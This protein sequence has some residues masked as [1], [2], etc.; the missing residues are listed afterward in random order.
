ML[1]VVVVSRLPKLA[2]PAVDPGRPLVDVDTLVAQVLTQSGAVQSRV[3]HNMLHRLTELNSKQQPVT[4]NIVSATLRTEA[5]WRMAWARLELVTHSSGSCR[6][7]GTRAA[8]SAA[9][10]TAHTGNGM[11]AA[12]CNRRKLD[13]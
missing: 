11:A 2:Q 1:W 3:M 12:W 5:S 8:D 6:P 9:G 4:S 7:A 10:S 13:N